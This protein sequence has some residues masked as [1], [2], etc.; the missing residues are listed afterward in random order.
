MIGLLDIPDSG[1]YSLDDI[2]IS[3]L[4]DN[5][6][7]VLRNKKIGFV[8]QSFNLLPKLN[9]LEN[10]QVPLMYQGISSMEE[11]NICHLSYRVGSNKE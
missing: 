8:F 6:L 2:E 1:N 7:A 10:V 5:K 4:T 11:K 9:A 3:S